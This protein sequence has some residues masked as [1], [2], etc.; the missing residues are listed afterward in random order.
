MSDPVIVKLVN[1][2]M[3]MAQVITDTT[4]ALIVSDPVTIKTITVAAEGGSVD[5]TITLP[6]CSLTLDREFSI[7]RSHVLFVKPLN[8]SLIK[9]YDKIV[10]A[11]LEERSEDQFEEQSIEDEPGDNHFLIIPDNDTVH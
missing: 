4:H 5:K 3:F 11:F 2:D 7:D 8:P 10:E 6:F 1:G 9:H